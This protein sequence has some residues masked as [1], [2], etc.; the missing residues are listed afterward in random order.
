MAKLLCVQ[1][2][3]SGKVSGRLVSYSTPSCGRVGV[4]L[5]IGQVN[6]D[7][8]PPHLRGH[9]PTAC[10]QCT[11]TVKPAIWTPLRKK[12]VNAS[13]ILCFHIHKHKIIILM[14]LP[15]TCVPTHCFCSFTDVSSQVLNPGFAEDFSRR[16]CSSVAVCGGNKRLD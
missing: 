1:K 15:D 9:Y 16:A 13:R 3:E 6:R 2:R 12:K 11:F 7:Y 4:E 5:S 8:T 14:T 10:F